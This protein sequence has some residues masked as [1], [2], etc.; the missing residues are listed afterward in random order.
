MN[1]KSAYLCLFG[2][3]FIWGLQ[4]I[5][6]KILLQQYTTITLVLMRCTLMIICYFLVV[7]LQEKRISLPSKKQMI[8]LAAM[9][10]CCIPINNI[11][12]F[13]GLHY[14]TAIHCALL[15]ATV[16]SIT[17]V[18]AYFML[19][20]R[21]NGLQWLGI[22]ISFGGVFCMLTH[23]DIDMV[24]ANGFNIGDILIIISEIGWSLYIVLGRKVMQQLSPTVTSAWA[25]LSGTVMIIPYA[26]NSENLAFSMPSWH[27]LGALIFVVVCSG[28]L[29]TII[30]NFGVNNIG[31]SKSAIFSNVTPF[32]G[33]IF[34][35]LILGEAFSI[36]D[37]LGMILVCTGVYILINISTNK[38]KIINKQITSNGK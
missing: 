16:P 25:S 5:M 22:F 35:N 27:T 26:L 9:G 24:L 6:M 17:A 31:A 38:I 37:I 23:G 32:T 36:Y 21:L 30:W 1:N 2:A 18:L 7:Y 20:E 3:T 34:S 29:A 15:G 13:E 4:A 33:L 8:I 28:V 11:T 19:K 10:F 14:T 12:Q